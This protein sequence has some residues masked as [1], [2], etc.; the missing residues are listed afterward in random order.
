[1]NHGSLCNLPGIDNVNGTILTFD[2]SISTTK[3]SP[4]S[5][6]RGL[7]TNSNGLP[8]KAHCVLIVIV[9][10]TILPHRSTCELM[11]HSD[12]SSLWEQPF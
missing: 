3:F 9:R 1:M 11:L 12:N 10:A 2:G 4:Y 7:L 5:A 6:V 8:Q